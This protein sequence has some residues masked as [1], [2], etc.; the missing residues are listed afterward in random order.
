MFLPMNPSSMRKLML[1]LVAGI[2][3]IPAHRSVAQESESATESTVE[4][5]EST[6][7]DGLYAKITTN[8]GDILCSL[9]YKKTP[10]TVINFTGLAEGK[11]K[12]DQKNGKPYYDGLKFHR[13][14]NDFM[15]QG[16][17]PQ[18]TGRGGPGYKFPDEI[19][20]DLK[21]TGPG[22]LSMANSGPATNGSQFFITHKATEWLDGKHTVFGKVVEGMDVVNSI[23]KDD[24]IK[25]VKVVRVG[26][27]ATSF[28]NTQAEFD[29]LVKLNDPAVRQKELLAKNLEKCAA[30]LEDNKSKDGVKVTDSGLQYK[31]VKEGNGNKPKATSEVEVH[32]EGSLIDGTVFDSSIKRGKTVTFP[33]NRV[34]P[35]WT[36]GLQLMSEGCTAYLYI[37]SDL[38]YGDRDIGGGLIPGGST[39]VFKVELVKIVK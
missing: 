32:Y 16:G 12:N 13:V 2:A 7:K 22:I 30:F 11:L 24:F 18:G 31:I 20:P 10:M 4:K 25:T 9:E 27:E 6:L 34:I 1:V 37:P 33:L 15:I 39:L 8:K 35:G 21:H 17:C 36:E 3:L 38:A 23:K 5:S 19:H 26:E 28:Q 14:I 29:R